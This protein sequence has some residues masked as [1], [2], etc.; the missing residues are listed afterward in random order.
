M[1]YTVV[2]L[3][4]GARKCRANPLLLNQQ[5]NMPEEELWPWTKTNGNPPTLQFAEQV[6]ACVRATGAKGV[7]KVVFGICFKFNQC[8]CLAVSVR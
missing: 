1:E 5:H 7:A 3:R 2:A 6:C 4:P 8:C